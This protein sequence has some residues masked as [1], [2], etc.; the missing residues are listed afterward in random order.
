MNVAK[1]TANYQVT[2]YPT[3]YMV[4]KNGKIYG[5]MIGALSYEMMGEMIEQ[6]KKGD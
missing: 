6:T 1:V 4:D 2:S 3:T 5:K